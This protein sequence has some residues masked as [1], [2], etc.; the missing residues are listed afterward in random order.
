MKS[1]L[2]DSWFLLLNLESW[3]GFLM[4]DL[5]VLNQSLG[6]LASS[7][8]LGSSSWSLLLHIALQ[9]F[10]PN[11]KKKRKKREVNILNGRCDWRK[12]LCQRCFCFGV[13]SQDFDLG[14]LEIWSNHLSLIKYSDSYAWGNII[15]LLT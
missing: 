9:I 5:E 3:I 13:I 6:L 8:L 10:L 14:V 2:F 15:P 1:W 11:K 4:L 7:K 12:W